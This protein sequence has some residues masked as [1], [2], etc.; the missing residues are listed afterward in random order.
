MVLKYAF[1]LA[2]G[3]LSRGKYLLPGFHSRDI[4]DKKQF[5]S[6]RDIEGQDTISWLALGDSYT[7]GESVQAKDCYAVQAV[8]ILGSPQEKY[9]PPEILA[10]TGWTTRELARALRDHPPGQKIYGIVTLLIGV[11]NLYQ[12]RELSEYRL[13]LDGL[14]E[15]SVSYSGGRP[16][17]VVLI[18]IPDFSVSPFAARMDR[19]AISR[20]TD[21]FNAVARELAIKHGIQF[22]DITPQTRLAEGNPGKFAPDGLHFSGK[23][24]A[25]WAGMLAPLIQHMGR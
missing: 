23:E 24:Y 4:M 25:A 20:Q 13:E 9:S 19:A 12:G 17:H 14:I 1:L 8:S 7:I 2:V 5:P 18:S 10:R 3:F 15:Q 22:L 21:R 11:N 6:Q 16:A